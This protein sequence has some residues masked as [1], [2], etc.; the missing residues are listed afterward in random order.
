[1]DMST[2]NPQGS[3]YVFQSGIPIYVIM[4]LVNSLRE[5]LAV[6]NVP[7]LEENLHITFGS[8]H[9]NRGAGEQRK[10]LIVHQ[11]YNWCTNVLPGLYAA[12]PDKQITITK[13]GAIGG[14]DGMQ[15]IAFIINSPIA[16]H[17]QQS[18]FQYITTQLGLD[19]YDDGVWGALGSTFR[20]FYNT[21]DGIP[22]IAIN[23]S[24]YDPTNY[25]PHISLFPFSLANR[26][27]TELLFGAYNEPALAASLQYDGYAIISVGPTTEWVRMS[28][29]RRVFKSRKKFIKGKTKRKRKLQRIKKAKKKVQC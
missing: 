21:G 8:I 7:D 6:L 14:I 1:M 20:V 28:G 25:H 18:L 19:G 15:K 4:H 9:F 29:G 2:L 22:V 11:I 3:T 27:A 16:N 5:K 12:I 17:L 24:F 13:V 26:S 23:L 10:N